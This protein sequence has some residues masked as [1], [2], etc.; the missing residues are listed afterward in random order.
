MARI[1]VIDDDPLYRDMVSEALAAEGHDLQVAEN[2]LEGL[3]RARAWL[4]DLI[5]CDVV[6][7]G[8]DGYQV[9][10]TLRGEP[11]TAAVPFIMMTGWSSQ[12][13]QRQ[14][15]N[16]GAD[17]YLPKPFNATELLEAVKV[18]LR[19]HH[20]T[21]SRVAFQSL[22]EETAVTSLL[23][24]QV[25]RSLQNLHGAGRLLTERG[26][27]LDRDELLSTGQRVLNAA[28]RIQRAV[29]NFALY[30]QLVRLEQRP[31]SDRGLEGMRV[32]EA[33]GF[34]EVRATQAARARQREADLS[35][36]LKPGSLA[37]APEFLGRI[38]DELL[39]NAFAFSVPGTRVEVVSA[40]APERF[41]LAI[42]DHGRGM[43]EDQIARVDAFVQF[44]T[45]Q[46]DASGLSL[47]LAIVRR[48]ANLHGGSLSIKSKPGEKTR[49]SVELPVR[50]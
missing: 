6:M 40:F 45:A 31:P 19:K 50:V 23:P 32:D 47:G 24:A 12:G 26:P 7:E 3:D 39:D 38:L 21:S 13:G 22:R 25:S 1:L 15:M 30:H 4:P 11:A 18:Q 43:S 5:I 44:G 37:M 46:A 20:L 28:W 27:E 29:D 9:L 17:D 14:G 35:L 49:V 33:A 41:G 48:I 42:T 10:A 16:M 34:L 8:A 36:N 2:G